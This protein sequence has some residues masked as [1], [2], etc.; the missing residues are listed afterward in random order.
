MILIFS[1]TIQLIVLRFSE[2]VDSGRRGYLIASIILFLKTFRSE[3]VNDSKKLRTSAE[4][5]FISLGQT[6]SGKVISSQ[7]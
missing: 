7:I 6:E 3:H 1:E 2:V 4:K 5:Q